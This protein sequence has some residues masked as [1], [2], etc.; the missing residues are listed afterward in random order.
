MV[1]WENIIKQA[2][3]WNAD[4][5]GLSGLI[6][7]SLDEM[8][9][10]AK[11]M[12]RA[13][14]KIPL[15]IGGATTSKKHTAVKIEPVYSGPS[16]HVT[17]ASRAVTVV[18][19]LISK[20][21]T[22][23]QDIRN[24][25]K[26]IRE[27]FKDA[28]QKREFLPLNKARKNRTQ[29][30]WDNYIPPKPNFIGTRSIE[31]NVENLIPYIDW[32]PYFWTW[33]IH[34][35]Y[36]EML[37]QDNELGEKSREVLKDAENLLDQIVNENLLTP[38]GIHG[39][40]PAKNVNDDIFVYDENKNHIETFYFLRQQM[41]KNDTTP[42]R[43]LS[44]FIA[45]KEKNIQDYIGAFSV[46]S[47]KEVEMLA[48]AYRD[49]NDDYSCILIQA[50]GDRLAEAFAE[51]LHEIT[52][53]EWG[54]AKYE[55]LSVEDMIKEKYQGIRPAAGYPACP[56]H[57]EK[58]TLFRLLKTEKHT[59]IILTESMAMTPASSVSGLY[60]SHPESRYFPLGRINKDQTLDYAKR[61]GWSEKTVEKWLAPNLGYEPS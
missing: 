60:F 56:D 54:Y 32:M 13:N 45:P 17:D 46:T 49:D 37:E 55:N 53:K 33:D 22:Y 20:N 34:G 2:Q 6:T 10:V 24:E 5:I 57:T 18:Q 3:E 38:K 25:Y 14:L 9:T 52:R 58:Q 19:S 44:D 29:I 40:F 50:I 30:E 7:P 31:V 27:N 43:S 42:N 21:I 26:S 41:K 4:I 11:E 35:R 28:E 1:P 61:K 59:N 15:L 48:K 12:E 23:I 16:I 51:Y 36:P 47:G 8:V 39:F